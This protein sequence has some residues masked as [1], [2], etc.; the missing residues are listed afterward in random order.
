MSDFTLQQLKDA[1]NQLYAQQDNTPRVVQLPAMYGAKLSC[2]ELI[3]LAKC[4]NVEFIGGSYTIGALQK[5][6]EEC[7]VKY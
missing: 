1:I 7:G 6:C 4:D 3:A 2:E 5:R